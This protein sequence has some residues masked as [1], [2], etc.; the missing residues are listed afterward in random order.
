[1]PT[2]TGET[3]RPRTGLLEGLELRAP[4][5]SCSFKCSVLALGTLTGETTD[6]TEETEEQ[7]RRLPGLW[8]GWPAAGAVLTLQPCCSKGLKLPLR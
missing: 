5:L 8:P 7:R 6:A 4:E 2:A 3:P 1:V